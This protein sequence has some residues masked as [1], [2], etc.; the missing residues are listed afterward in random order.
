MNKNI[1]RR[2]MAR[3]YLEYT[4]NTFLDYPDYFMFA[5][6]FIMSIILVSFSDVL[7][8]I[9]RDSF[10]H[11]FNFTV[12]AMRDTSWILQLLIAGFVIRVAISGSKM[13]YRN[14]KNMNMLSGRIMSK[15]R[16]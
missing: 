2:I 1:K 15:F 11:F 3:V 9:P 4:K 12:V 13:A 6:F 14:M 16:Y 8:N 5:F 7:A 10:P